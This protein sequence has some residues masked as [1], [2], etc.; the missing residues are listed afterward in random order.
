MTVA[1]L[2]ETRGVA[3]STTRPTTTQDDGGSIIETYATSI[4][5][6]TVY[7]QRSS[8]T[9]R[10]VNGALRMVTPTTGYALPGADILARDRLVSG[11]NTWEI[12]GI[13]T[14]D[15]LA[16]PDELAYMILDLTL[17]TGQP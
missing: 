2:I 15:E 9:E 5:A 12:T 3:C 4:A 11:A 1:N 8:P 6:L 16:S 13:V 10:V 14:P 7:I 17:I